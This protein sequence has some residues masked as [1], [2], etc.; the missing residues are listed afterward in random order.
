MKQ[1]TTTATTIG[2]FGGRVAI[3]FKKPRSSHV[4]VWSLFSLRQF[5]VFAY[6]VQTYLWGIINCNCRMQREVCEKVGIALKA[7]QK[8]P[9]M[10]LSPGIHLDVSSLKAYISS[11]PESLSQPRRRRGTATGL[12]CFGST[13]LPVGFAQLLVFGTT[14]SFEASEVVLDG[15]R[16][17]TCGFP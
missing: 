16:C 3:A 1:S 9:S 12:V 2:R 7:N 15:A 13:R 4:T 17:I 11:S 8:D 14:V 6:L 10:R 5:I